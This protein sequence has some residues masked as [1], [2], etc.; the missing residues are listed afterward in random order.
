MWD[1]IDWMIE[2]PAV[3][4]RSCRTSAARP[5]RPRPGRNR[6]ASPRPASCRD[7]YRCLRA[8]AR[9]CASSP[10]G[11]TS[12][13][14]SP[15]PSGRAGCAQCP[16]CVDDIGHAGTPCNRS[17]KALVPGHTAIARGPQRRRPSLAADPV[18]FGPLSI[19]YSAQDLHGS[20]RARGAM[21]MKTL[22]RR[23]MVS[24]APGLRDRGRRRRHAGAAAAP[25]ADQ[26]MGITWLPNTNN[27]NSLPVR[28]GTVVYTGGVQATDFKLDFVGKNQAGVRPDRRG[29]RPVQHLQAKPAVRDHPDE[30]PDR[31]RD[32]RRVRRLRRRRRQDEMRDPD[33]GEEAQRDQCR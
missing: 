24:A 23:D 4:S 19:Q 5:S 3:R 7:G 2:V 22:N 11:P 21:P 8:P 12:G 27:F 30:S 25:A 33:D 29:A 6:R 17:Q 10:S 31:S 18:A 9:T 16:A 32:R 1:S 20:L 26:R 28:H 14:S 13:S 15:S